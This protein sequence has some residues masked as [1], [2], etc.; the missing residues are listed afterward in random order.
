MEFNKGLNVI[1][2]ENDAGKTSLIDSL[3]ILFGKKKIDSNDFNEI[4]KPVT[5]EL[6]DIDYTYFMESKVNED[7]VTSIYKIKP[8]IE[9]IKEIKEELESEEFN[10][11][12][13]SEQKKILKKHSFTFNIT[14]RSNSRV[15]TLKENILKAL[16]KEDFTEVKSLNYPNYIF[17]I[18]S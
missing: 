15:E 6:E 17:I 4:E 16:E 1:I 18:S 3:K 2:G 10:N 9:T 12:E 11:L 5:I 14:Y 13:E 7:T 8:S